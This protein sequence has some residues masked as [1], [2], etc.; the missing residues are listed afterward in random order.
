MDKELVR[1]AHNFWMTHTKGDY[2]YDDIKYLDAYL[3]FSE[4]SDN[5]QKKK[6][7]LIFI[8]LNPPY[9]EFLQS[10]VTE[11]KQ[12]FLPGHDVDYFGW[13]DIP[14]DKEGIDNVIV[15]LK[16]KEP[17]YDVEAN[18]KALMEISDYVHK[19]LTV[20]PTEGVAWPM[21]TLMRYHLFLQQ[22][23]KLKEYDYIFYCDADMKFV[24]VVGDEI[25]GEGLTGAQHPM[26]ARRTELEY[27]LEPNQ[28]S[29]AFIPYPK[30]YYAGGFQGGKTEDFIKAMKVMKRA[31]DQDF[32]KNYTARWNDESHWNRYL[33]D[34]PPAITL[35]PSYVYPDS[36]IKEYYTKIWGRDYAPKLL[37]LTKK[38]TTDKAGGEA[39]TKMIN[40]L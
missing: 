37:T 29:Q 1:K 38:F 27:P 9:W 31:I 28:E 21:P 20:F 36:L 22:E 24:N 25:L 4:K 15:D 40:S 14:Q 19:N 7:A 11:A 8:C 16:G 34:N 5:F 23:E 10:V 18:T 12:F 35:S 39:V 26:Y 6:V 33:Y 2:S 13:S 32:N 17:I 3:K 30:H